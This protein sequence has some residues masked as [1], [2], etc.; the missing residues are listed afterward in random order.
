VLYRRVIG[1]S[2]PFVALCHCLGGGLA[3]D[4]IRAARQVVRVAVAIGHVDPP[5]LLVE[6]MEYGVKDSYLLFQHE[7]EQAPLT[8]GAIAAAVIR[9]DLLRKLRAVSSGIASTSP[10]SAT[11]LH[12]TLYQIRQTLT[13]GQPVIH[14]VDLMTAACAG[15]PAELT[16]LRLDFAAYAYYCATL[17]EV[18]TDQLDR[19]RMIAATSVPPGP[20]SFDALASA[21]VAFS[22]DTQLAWRLITQFR[23]AWSLETREP[24]PASA[25]DGPPASRKP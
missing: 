6:E 17:Q 3:R 25:A 18:F 22:L 7:S 14:A 21:R 5:S 13:L 19:E 20:G 4:V 2:E 23:K 15:E 9:D 24:A 10:A 16:R 1:L 12:D 8:L 11:D